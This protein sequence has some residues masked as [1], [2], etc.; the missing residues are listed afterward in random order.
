M[1]DKDGHTTY[2]A[3][4]ERTDAITLEEVSDFV[5]NHDL[6]QAILDSVDG[7]IMILN[8][9]RQVLAMNKQLLQDLKIETP[10]CAIGDRPGEILKCIHAAEGP[11]GCGTSK[12]CE[13][14]GA[15]ISILNSQKD[16]KAITNECLATVKQGTQSASVEFRVR[17]T[18][19]TVEGYTFTV[20]VFHDISGEKRR[21]ALERT[22]FHDILNTVG[23]LMGWGSLLQQYTSSTN[24]QEVAERIV[25]LSRR[26]KQEIEDQRRL[27]QAEQGTLSLS[28][29]E[30]SVQEIFQGLS[31]VFEAHPIS[32]NRVLEIK[33]VAA[34][35]SIS[36]DATLLLR[37]L[38][39]MTKNALEAAQD[40]DTI[41]IW[42]ERYKI[43]AKFTVHN[44]G[45]IPE[46]VAVQI[47]NRSFSTKADKGRGIGTYS[48]KLFGERYLGGKV[49]FDSTPNKGT[50][51]YIQLP[52]SLP[53]NN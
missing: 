9:E 7:Y 13:T 3:P 35:E 44:P 8:P 25:V 4:A 46:K 15:V 33:P 6:F 2:F 36:T 49:G 14:C 16:G 42:Y 24:P 47:F 32:K 30:I 27:I 12:S 34:E 18:P 28:I 23:G 5:Q 31:S 10:A 48:M 19:V 21:A 41:K 43:N 38:T 17:A 40:N 51:F 52:I 50:I 1:F 11:N 22:F 20:M 39:N 37:V 45:V 53:Q 26:L 29:S